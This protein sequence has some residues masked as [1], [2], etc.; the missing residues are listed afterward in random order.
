MRFV[1][2]FCSHAWT[3]IAAV[4]CDR[5]RVAILPPAKFMSRWLVLE[6]LLVAGFCRQMAA[7]I[8]QEQF[9]AIKKINSKMS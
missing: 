9:S 5:A 4:L 7:R 8:G 6:F 3:R 1:R 2:Y